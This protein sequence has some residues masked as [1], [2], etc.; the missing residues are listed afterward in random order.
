[1]V[2]VKCINSAINWGRDAVPVQALGE[3]VSVAVVTTDQ[4]A[5]CGRHSR[6][7]CSP[8][9]RQQKRVDG[10]YSQVRK[11]RLEESK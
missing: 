5:R 4:Q 3:K 2:A 8:K 10:A 1:V 11:L 9:H 6:P 7:L